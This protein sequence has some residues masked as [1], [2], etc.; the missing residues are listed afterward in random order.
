[1]NFCELLCTDSAT[2]KLSLV[3]LSV[4]YDLFTSQTFPVATLISQHGSTICSTVCS[5]VWPCRINACP[6]VCTLS[7]NVIS[8]PQTAVSYSRET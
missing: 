4:D 6:A 1:M 8:E 3:S 5:H 7:P 2:V